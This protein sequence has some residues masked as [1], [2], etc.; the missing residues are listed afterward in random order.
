MR[1]GIQPGNDLRGK[2]MGRTA[3]EML[4]VYNAMPPKDRAA[5]IDRP[6]IKAEWE[7]ANRPPPKPEKAPAEP[8]EEPDESG[9]PFSELKPKTEVPESAKAIPAGTARIEKPPFAWF[10][11]GSFSRLSAV[12]QRV[13]WPVFEL[14]P[15]RGEVRLDVG[16]L[17]RGLHL[18]RRAT[19]QGV[20]DLA[21]A[22]WIRTRTVS[23]FQGK[24]I[25]V[26]RAADD[27][28]RKAVGEKRTS[29]KW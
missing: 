1:R 11:D 20:H 6:E 21:L 2:L 26:Q 17:A 4:E 13:V 18:S 16:W 15:E 3:E 10:K 25:L 28:P 23:G 27:T 29:G 7:A 9:I 5:W 14:T 19:A 12:A 24:L 8:V 22:G